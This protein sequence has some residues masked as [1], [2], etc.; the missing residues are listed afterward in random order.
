MHVISTQSAQHYTW[1]QSCDGWHLARS[2]N[3]SVI[4]ERMPPQTSETAHYHSRSSQFF[5][6]LA[7]TLS[8]QI[9]GQTHVLSR[10]H[11]LEIPPKISH[12]AFNDTDV[13]TSFL[14]VSVP[15]SHDD[16]IEVS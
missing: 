13:E 12:R 16:R 11:G 14:V 10:D 4:Q 7:G 6:V 9:N 8:I 5:F 1:G 15:P 3:L 2:H